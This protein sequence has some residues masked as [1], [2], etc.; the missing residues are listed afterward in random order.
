MGLNV[1]SSWQILL[2]FLQCIQFVLT[3]CVCK[4]SVSVP[5]VWDYEL[6]RSAEH[7]AHTCLW[8]H[9][10]THLL[11]QIGQN[12]GAHWGRCVCVVI[13]DVCICE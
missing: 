5:Q 11:T 1:F 8:E 4:V 10:P 3:V 9:G 13:F 12:L 2:A 6:E 7:W